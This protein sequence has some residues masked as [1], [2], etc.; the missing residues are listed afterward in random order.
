MFDIKTIVVPTDFSKISFSAFEY[1]RN[2]A[3]RM[4]AEIHLVYVME[5]TP[6]FIAVKSIDMP[7][8]EILK[9]MEIEAR[10]KLHETASIFSEDTNIKIE[11]VLRLGNDFEEIVNYSK[12][13]KADLIVIATHGR[14]GVLHSLLGSVAEKVIR[15][16]RC[17]VLVISPKDDDE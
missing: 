3:E 6:P 5:K 7:E 11:E 1:A 15:F 8:D 16:S 4:N 2:L 17:P 9:K 14:T 12:E 13:I 10:K